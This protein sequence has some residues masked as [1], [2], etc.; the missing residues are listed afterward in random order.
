M[1][2]LDL[3]TKD[4]KLSNYADDT[5]SLCV[6]K[7]K[8]EAVKMTTEEANNIINFFSANDLKNNPDKSC[9][10]YNSK[11]HGELITLE[12]VG[13]E[14]LTSLEEG[15]SEKLLGLHISR[16]FNWKIHVDKLAS[17]LN[18]KLAL[19]RRMRSRIPRKKLLMVSQ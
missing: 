19:I 13:G 2:D 14:K 12:N 16:E 5:Q 1:A 9:V 3:W 18:K 17:D 10:I 4:C 7:D 8:T 15:K 11:G 6:A